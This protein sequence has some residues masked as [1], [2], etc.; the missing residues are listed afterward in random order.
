MIP[1]E[2]SLSID[3][4]IEKVVVPLR[5]PQSIL[6]PFI[7]G[8]HGTWAHPP[9]I[10]SGD[11]TTPC[12]TRTASR[13]LY[14]E[15]FTSIFMVRNRVW[16]WPNSTCIL[17]TAASIGIWTLSKCFS[18]PS[19]EQPLANPKPFYVLHNFHSGIVT[20]G[21]LF[22]GTLPSCRGSCRARRFPARVRRGT[23]MCL[24]HVALCTIH[25]ASRSWLASGQDSRQLLS[26]LSP[27]KESPIFASLCDTH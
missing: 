3:R 26:P 14:S 23:D 24:W 12:D 10:H 17:C 16:P 13:L 2:Q 27:I 1:R 18:S 21:P 6:S 11:S 20:A 9:H 4:L 15:Y 5:S 22:V 25:A 19:L 8:T 7:L